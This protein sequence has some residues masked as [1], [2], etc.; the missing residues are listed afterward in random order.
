[1][2]NLLEFILIHLVDNPDQVN[3]TV[4]DQNGTEVYILS[5]AAA[6]MGKIIG[7]QGKVINAIRSIAKVRAVKERKHIQITLAEVDQERTETPVAS[8]TI[9]E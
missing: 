6:D 5:V 4:E 1:M 9:S 2:K 3:I 8:E 7:R